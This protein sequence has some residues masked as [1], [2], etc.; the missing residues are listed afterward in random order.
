MSFIYE[1]S[2]V[3]AHLNSW[4]HDVYMLTS[5]QVSELIMV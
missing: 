2:K 5:Q 1:R 4:G 3:G